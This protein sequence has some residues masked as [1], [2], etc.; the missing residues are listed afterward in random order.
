[1][2]RAL[3]VGSHGEIRSR[4]HLDGKHHTGR[5]PRKPDRW[6]AFT[7]YRDH[8]GVVRELQR[9]APTETGARHALREYLAQRAGDTTNRV[10][11]TPRV[12]DIAA[13]YLT[14]TRRRRTGTT[15]DRYRGRV[16]HHI[17][18]RIGDLRITECTPGRIHTTLNDIADDGYAPETLRGI[19]ACISGIMQIAINH[20]IITT[21]PARNVEKLEGGPV[22]AAEAFDAEQLV[23]FLQKVDADQQAARADL[24]DLIRFWFGTGVRYGEALAVRWGDCNLTDHTITVRNPEGERAKLPPHTVWI[25]GN[26]VEVAG[27][28]IIRHSGKTSSSI[29][30]IGLP[31]FLH[32]ILLQRVP[33]MVAAGAGVGEPV[34]PSQVMGWRAP[35]NVQRSVRRLRRRIGYPEFTTHVPRK[36][37]ADVLDQAGQ[38][39]SQI[40]KQLR[41]SSIRTTERHY[42]K[43]RLSNPA[44]AKAID[45]AFVVNTPD[46]EGT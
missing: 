21:N 2:S 9:S 31:D 33:T 1:M 11:D 44:A 18:P 6:T 14:E 8:D 37:V 32:A 39:V 16:N 29:G 43:R 7:Q 38:S 24:P 42:I 34:F 20:D 27:Q 5:P 41:Q 28:G 40:A 10:G 35:S 36:T 23:D 26:L 13:L 22:R 30:V 12:K 4:Y 25:N 45:A 3:A 46:E 19:R 15:Y 17:L